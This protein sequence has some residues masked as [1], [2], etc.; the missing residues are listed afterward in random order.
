[1]TITR[2]SPDDVVIWPD[3]TTATLDDLHRGEFSHMSDDHE[4]VSIDDAARLAVLGLT[5]DCEAP[6]A[7]RHADRDA[8]RKALVFIVLFVAFEERD[9]GTGRM[10]RSL[11]SLT[12][13]ARET[14]STIRAALR[15]NPD[16]A[17]GRSRPDLLTRMRAALEHPA[18]LSDAAR[19]TLIEDLDATYH[20]HQ[21]PERRSAHVAA[22]QHDLGYDVFAAFGRDQLDRMVA[23]FCRERWADTGDNRDPATLDDATVTGIWFDNEQTELKTMEIVDPNYSPVDAIAAEAH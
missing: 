13:M 19:R 2:R 8:L 7:H 18:A 21:A 4:I 15:G 11:A 22:I 9:R 12:A 3:G 1:M 5:P 17:P 6:P 14:D 10:D 20:A 16:G 23:G